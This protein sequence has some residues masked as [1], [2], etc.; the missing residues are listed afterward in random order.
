MLRLLKNSFL[1][2]L[3]LI[4]CDQCIGFLLER[5]FY[6]Q[7]HGDDYITLQVLD[8]SRA[9]MIVMGSSRASHHYIPDT[10]FKQCGLSTFNGGRDNMGIHYTEAITAEMLKRYHPVCIVFDLIPYNFINDNQNNEKYFD[11]QTTCLLPFAHRHPGL[12]DFI[13]TIHP[14]EAWKGKLIRSYAYNS[15]AGSIFQNAYTKI[16]HNQVKGYEPL[17]GKIDSLHYGKQVYRFQNIKNG[18]D[19][20]AF[21]R[22]Q[23]CLSLCEQAHVKAIICFSPFYFPYHHEAAL[24]AR[25][26]T[27][28]NQFHARIYDYSA[29]PLFVKNADLFYD[30]LHLNDSGATL[31]SKKLAGALRDDLKSR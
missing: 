3:V 14:A 21:A 31:F 28:A 19:T 22:L 27:M 2:L 20:A 18:I 30:E 17:Y 23:H 16:G 29:D 11:I 12:Y 7:H 15:L 24:I 5:T 13:G 26:Q 9:D 4:A 6:K 10:L 25:F 8:S 1:L